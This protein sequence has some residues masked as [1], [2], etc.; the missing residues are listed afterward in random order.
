MKYH[1][2]FRNTGYVSGHAHG[3]YLKGHAPLEAGRW[4]RDFA[5]VV[6]LVS[7]GTDTDD[8]N[9]MVCMAAHFVMVTLTSRLFRAFLPVCST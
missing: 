3:D 4:N 8:V 1:H 9:V 7:D 5:V 2:N 6:D